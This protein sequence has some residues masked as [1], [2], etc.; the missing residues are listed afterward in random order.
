MAPGH[1]MLE[2]PQSVADGNKVGVGTIKD[3]NEDGA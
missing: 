1:K 2:P 3:I